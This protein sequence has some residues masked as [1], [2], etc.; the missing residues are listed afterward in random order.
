[1]PEIKITPIPY[2]FLG[3]PGGVATLDGGG[4][5]PIG[6]LPA[7][8]GS[9][10]VVAS[11]AAMLAL[12]DAPGQRAI[13]T[14]LTPDQIFT[15]TQ[16]PATVLANWQITTADVASEVA[17]VPNGNIASTN[18]QDA[19]VEVRDDAA[20]ALSTHAGTAASET[21][22]A[23][24]ELA[25]QTEINTG[26]DTVRVPTP[27]TLEGWRKFRRVKS[28]M[29]F[30]TGG[31]A[32]SAG[33]IGSI[34]VGLFN[35][36][37]AVRYV[38]RISS[39]WDLTVN[40]KF[41]AQVFSTVLPVVTLATVAWRVEARYIAIGEDATIAIAETFPETQVLT[42]FANRRQAELNVELD[43]SLMAN[44]DLIVLDV[45]RMG[46]GEGDTYPNASEAAIVREAEFRVY[47]QW[48][49]LS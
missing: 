11:E 28:E 6:Q 16:S 35:R 3:Q 20:S 12:P 15:Q 17:F 44:G 10:T 29:A 38:T 14:D 24:V 33:F 45:W 31:S 4:T 2:S 18:V 40:P 43:A 46:A 48:G 7:G 27:A 36:N 25:T 39:E 8:F 23:H 22:S 1:M 5:I 30:F 49:T 21:T 9:P 42:L 32:A 26:L 47:G 41:R 13:R 34:P 19:I 37:E